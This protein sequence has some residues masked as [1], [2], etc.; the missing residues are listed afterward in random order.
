[1]VVTPSLLYG[2]ETWVPRKAKEPKQDSY[3]VHSLRKIMKVRWWHF[4]Q[5]EDIRKEAGTVT[6]STR[7]MRS[8]LRWFG[9]ITRMEKSRILLLLPLQHP[10]EWM[11]M[12]RKTKTALDRYDHVKL[13]LNLT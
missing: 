2:S 8:K 1:M 13:A 9:H 4:R 6:P 3:D 5:N 7:I 10:E 11:Q 12:Q